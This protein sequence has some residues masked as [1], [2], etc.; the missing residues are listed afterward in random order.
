MP[1]KIGGTALGA[2]HELAIGFESVRSLLDRYD[3]RTAAKT[4]LYELDRGRSIT[5]GELREFANILLGNTKVTEAAA[6]LR[7]TSSRSD[8]W[9]SKRPPEPWGPASARG[10]YSTEAAGRR[11]SSSGRE[12]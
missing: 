12:F 11:N 2:R 10:R 9:Q 8:E 1:P 4:A 6:R 5:F 7:A 3:H